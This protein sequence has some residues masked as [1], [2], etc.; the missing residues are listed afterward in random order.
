[1]SVKRFGLP[2]VAGLLAGM[3]LIGIGLGAIGFKV[4]VSDRSSSDSATPILESLVSTDPIS[5]D[6][7]SNSVEVENGLD[8]PPGEETTDLDLQ[9]IAEIEGEFARSEAL[10][11]FLVS[12]DRNSLPALIEQTKTI[13]PKT[14]QAQ[15]RRPIVLRLTMIDPVLALK[16]IESL[17]FRS[18]DSLTTTIFGEW[19][20]LSLDQ[21]IAYAKGL[22]DVRKYAALRGILESRVDLSEQARRE[23]A[24]EVGNEIVADE[25]LERE[26]YLSLLEDPQKSW[27]KVVEDLDGSLESMENTLNVATAWVRQSGLG[28]LNEIN[29][30]L[31]QSSRKT[32][33]LIAAVT[34]AAHRNPSGT[35][36]QLL[37][38]N[39]QLARSTAPT[40]IR[41]WARM[42]PQ[43]ALLTAS[44][45]ESAGFR[46]SLQQSVVSEWA[47]NDAREL[48]ASIDSIPENVVKLAQERAVRALASSD[49]VEAARLFEVLDLKDKD[50]GI[51]HDI[52]S[53]WSKSEPHAAVDWVFNTSALESIQGELLKSVLG[54]LAKSDPDFAMDL[55]LQQ[56]AELGL[57]VAVISRLASVDPLKALDLLSQ[58]RDGGHVY[59]AYTSVGSELVKI[60]QTQRAIKLANELSPFYRHIYFNSVLG[61]WARS[62]P[63][64]LLESIDELPTSDAKSSAAL[65][66]A[67]QSRF[68]NSVL[69]DEQV[70]HAKTF[71]NERDAKALD[72]SSSFSFTVPGSVRIVG[73]ELLDPAQLD[74]IVEELTDGINQSLPDIPVN[75]PVVRETIIIE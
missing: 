57:E 58:L 50:V 51:A 30:S 14:V 66:L 1:M 37:E 27:Y 55:A 54:N 26:S 60:G 11:T 35:V 45:V 17:P 7:D 32:S 12:Q 43:S 47:K 22:N 62:N 48:L 31:N 21:S 40:A 5:S 10:H 42:D 19:S 13:R 2:A 68:T 72:S 70:A 9:S 29:D 41:I 4:L 6:T 73:D 67:M 71:L 59:S 56:P 53:N 23:I 28:V 63:E 74:A 34:R 36:T 20:L 8:D 75:G 64:E 49:P 3:L 61:Q 18:R 39:E 44:S 65:A 33:V 52:A 38:M 16:S 24:I 69:S 25:V 15:V 46:N